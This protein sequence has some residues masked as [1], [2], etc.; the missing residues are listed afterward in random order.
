MKF[1]N[2]QWLT[3]EGFTIHSPKRLHQKVAD[4][5]HLTLYAPN[6]YSEARAATLAGPLFTIVLSAPME[7]VIGV[8]VEHFRGAVGK[9][10]AFVLKTEAGVGQVGEDASWV[11]LA[12]GNLTAR[13]EKKPPFRIQYWDQDRLLTESGPGAMAHVVDSD[14]LTYMRDQLDLGVGESVYGLGERFTA[15]VKNGQNVE[16]WNQDGGTNSEQSYK[17]IP[18]YLTNRGYGVFVNY[19]GRVSFE[20]GSEKVSVVQFSVAGESLDY[21]VINGPSPKQVL[22]RY[23]AL[24]GRPA[25]PPAWSLGLWL[26]TSFTTDY[27]EKTANAFIEGMAERGIPLSVFHFDC[28]WMKEYEWCNFEWDERAYPDPVGMLERL[29]RRGLKVSVWINPYIGQRAALFDEAKALGYLIRR[30]N[31]DVWQWDMWQPGMAI[32]DFTNPEAKQWFKGKLKAL[33]AMGVDAF[34]TDFGERIPLEV[35]YFDRSDPEMMH[36]YYALLYNQ[37]V[38]EALAEERPHEAVLFARSAT[39]GG[40]QFPVHWGGDCHASYASMAAS[41]RGGLSLGLS[42]FG[43]WSHDIG[44]FE[45]TPTPDLYKRWIQFGLL[46]THS[47]L[48]GNSSYRVP[49]LFD[50]ESVEVLRYFSRLKNQLMPY[51]YQKSQEAHA[52]GWPVMRGMGFEFPHDP[53]CDGLDRQYMLGDALLVAPVF[54]ED[55]VVDFY[56]PDGLWTHLLSGEKVLGGGFRRQ[57]SDYFSL[58][59]FVRPNSLVAMGAVN[60]RPDYDFADQVTFHLFALG[61]GRTAETEVPDERGNTVLRAKAQR[62]GDEIT[63]DLE[64]LRDDKGVWSLCARGVFALVQSPAAASREV[65][66][67]GLHLHMSPGTE[68]VV[69]KVFEEKF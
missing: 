23:T 2:G 65:R 43:F 13:I 15:F 18:F 38:Y 6:Q 40:Q 29:H 30:P 8:R 24:T 53:G 50:E 5:N 11:W 55:G 51:L 63:V 46:S 32:V 45:G 64:D 1:S 20:V 28:F 48:H 62:K 41:L 52:F 44:G 21:L 14:G 66:P 27:D 49:W 36:N 34:K 7:D 16:V 39:V 33:L 19:P 9:G 67:E 54:S 69:L 58:P 59:V 3:R 60:E 26:T 22:S 17:N 10:P 56:L 42:G 31:G 35:Q 61:D 37:T 57:R 12:S 68:R 47:R 25:L 4:N